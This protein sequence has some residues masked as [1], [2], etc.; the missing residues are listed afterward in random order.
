MRTRDRWI[1]I[2]LSSLLL[3]WITVSSSAQGP[4]RGTGKWMDR[5]AE[6]LELTAEQRTKIESI[7]EK[8]ESTARALRQDER[9]AEHALEGELLEEQPNAQ[10][11]KEAVEQVGKI[12][13]QLRWQRL[14][15]HLAVREVLTPEQRE[16]FPW[17]GERR[18]HGMRG[19]RG[20]GDRERHHDRLERRSRDRRADWD[21]D[22]ERSGRFAD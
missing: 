19:A 11:V 17:M 1:G 2:G 22:G 6:R 21:D 14:E 10:R 15:Q 13:T 16:K 9:R 4:S 3:L 5:M 18:S 8:G 20:H 7:Q 12:Q